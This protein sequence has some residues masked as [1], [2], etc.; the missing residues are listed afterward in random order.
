MLASTT[1]PPTTPGERLMPHVI[2]APFT[3]LDGFVTD[4]N[5]GIDFHQPD[6]EV[7]RYINELEKT[8]S[9][10]IYGDR[11]YHVMNAWETLPGRICRIPSCASTPSIGEA[12]A[13]RLSR[14]HMRASTSGSTRWYRS[15]QTMYSR[16]SS[17]PQ[18]G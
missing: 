5:G 11:T 15:S 9:D 4:P 8:Y 6:E 3:S 14:T 16:G 18:P 7:H 17:R 12:C 13:R 1:D 10:H 2:Y